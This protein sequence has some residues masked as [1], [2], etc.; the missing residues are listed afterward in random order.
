MASAESSLDKADRNLC[1]DLV[2]TS[3]AINAKEVKKT[4]LTRNYQVPIDVLGTICNGAPL[5]C[6]AS[7]QVQRKVRSIKR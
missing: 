2:A 5:T 7:V 1:N 3:E 4:D 6:T